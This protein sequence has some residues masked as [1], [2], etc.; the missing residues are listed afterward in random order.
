M[1]FEI[2]QS[3]VYSVAV[4]SGL[5]IIIGRSRPNSVQSATDFHPF[6]FSNPSL[7]LPS[8]HTTVAF[9]LS[10]VLAANTDNNYLKVLAFFPAVLTATSRV[11]QN[12]HWASDVFLGAMVGYFTGKFITDLHKE[13]ELTPNI[14]NI[15]LITFSLNF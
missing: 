2:A 8:G 15:P 7:S 5:K 10:T 4:T 9:S 3:F 12:H 13:N 11:Y 14:N 6:S 1:S